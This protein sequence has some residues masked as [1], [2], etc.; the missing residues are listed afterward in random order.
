MTRLLRCELRVIY[1]SYTEILG[2][3][4]FDSPRDYCEEQIEERWIKNREV[5]SIIYWKASYAINLRKTGEY[6]S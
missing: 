2:T 4:L 5:P 6:S 1:F 3:H